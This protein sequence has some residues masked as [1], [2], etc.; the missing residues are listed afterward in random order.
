[1]EQYHLVRVSTVQLNGRAK[2]DGTARSSS[3]HMKLEREFFALSIVP[4]LLN[5][6]HPT[7]PP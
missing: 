2:T 3:E 6:K 5:T 4:Q 1:M 7:I